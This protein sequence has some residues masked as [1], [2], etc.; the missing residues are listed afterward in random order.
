MNSLQVRK[1]LLGERMASW[2]AGCECPTNKLG[3]TFCRSVLH[4]ELQI[5]CSQILNLVTKIKSRNTMHSWSSV[6]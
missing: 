3:A 5:A 2:R 4:F 1:A 6:C